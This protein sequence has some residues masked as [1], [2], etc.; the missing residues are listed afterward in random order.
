LV[1]MCY[2]HHKITNDVRRFPVS[3]LRRFKEDHERRF[4]Q[5]DR[6]ILDKLTDWTAVSQP[7][8]V[9]SLQR[10]NASLSGVPTRPNCVRWC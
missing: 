7:K 5:P 6:A 4:S 8:G 2:E 9:K 3:K 10:M 1:L